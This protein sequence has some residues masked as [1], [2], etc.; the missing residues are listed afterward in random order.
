MERRPRAQACHPSPAQCVRQKGI[1][2]CLEL[3]GLDREIVIRAVGVLE[4]KGQAKYDSLLHTIVTRVI[5]V[6]CAA[7][8]DSF[9]ERLQTTKGSSFLSVLNNRFI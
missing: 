9:A 8:I 4:A 2:P 7:N 5:A 3:E 6:L 1:V